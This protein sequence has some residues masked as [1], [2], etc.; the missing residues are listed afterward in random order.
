MIK[1]LIYRIFLFFFYF[2][3]VKKNLIV[4]SNFNGKKY[5]DNVKYIHKCYVDN[6]FFPNAI[7]ALIVDDVDDNSAPSDLVQIKKKSLKCAYYLSRAHVIISN[8]RMVFFFKK[9][10]QL[11]IQTWH[12]GGAQKKCENDVIESLDKKYVTNAI[13]DSKKIDI[14]LSDSS[15]MTN[16]YYKSFWYNGHVLEKGYP[17]N[18]VFSSS[19]NAYITSI[20]KEKFHIDKRYAIALYA[21]TFRDDEST[22]WLLNDF[23]YI[24][25]ALNKRFNKEFVLFV[26]FHPNTIINSDLIHFSK[27]VFNV[28]DYPDAQE[29]ELISEVLIGDY[30]SMNF[31]FAMQNKP[32]FRFVPDLE[33]FKKQRNF[34]FDFEEYPYPFATT[35]DELISLIYLFD[36]SKYLF[37]VHNFFN[38]IGFVLKNDAS[39]SVSQFI[40]NFLSCENK[41]IYFSK[42]KE[43]IIK[44]IK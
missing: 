26:R 38:K 10:T 36:M 21:P 16:L 7:F 12:G 40:S 19:E 5:G 18:D 1:N 43:K 9:K 15:F 41:L 2:L 28:T 31:E 20:V 33:R 13:K 27:R 6:N 30:S 22:D 39:Y 29:I 37:D 23:D 11:Y 32:V 35:K 8:V 25:D 44:E 3:P 17:R 24:I 34:Y 14:F 4:L 42:Y